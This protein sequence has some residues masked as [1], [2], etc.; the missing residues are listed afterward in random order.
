MKRRIVLGTAV[1]VLGSLGCASAPPGATAELVTLPNAERVFTAQRRG[2]WCWAACSEMALKYNG[3]EGVTQ[4]MLVENLRGNAEDQRVIDYQLIQ[5]LATEPAAAART[6][7]EPPR[8]VAINSAGAVNALEKGIAMYSSSDS[9]VEDFMGGH[10]VLMGLRN[11]KDAPGHIVFVTGMEVVRKE[12]LDERN[13]YV[14]S[15]AASL[16]GIADRFDGSYRYEIRSV[17]FFDPL[18][19]V[20]GVARLDADGLEAHQRFFLSRKRAREIVR[21]WNSSLQVR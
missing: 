9:A 21:D 8:G 20:G 7:S 18:P 1:G 6:G 3:V 15:I 17:E 11:W 5:A 4:E 12:G 13:P 16:N 2:D 10:P 19:D 14:G